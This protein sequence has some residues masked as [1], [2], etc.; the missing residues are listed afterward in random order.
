[1]TCYYSDS[2]SCPPLSVYSSARTSTSSSTNSSSWL[3]LQSDIDR[4]LSIFDTKIDIS[5]FE[6]LEDQLLICPRESFADLCYSDAIDTNSA[7]DPD[8]S[9][10]V[11]PPRRMNWDRSDNAVNEPEADQFGFLDRP[12]DIDP[13]AE[14]DSPT[15]DSLM[16]SSC[17]SS[18]FN[19]LGYT[20]PFLYGDSPSAVTIPDP[21]GPVHYSPTPATHGKR[22]NRWDR[23]ITRLTSLA[24]RPF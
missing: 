5:C 10:F 17:T 1:M 13:Y 2:D 18:E 15:T 7:N 23:T 3:S 14:P 24:R 19:D 9:I 6:D 21:Y 12:L 8:W 16:S 4:S 22:S 11:T 20:S